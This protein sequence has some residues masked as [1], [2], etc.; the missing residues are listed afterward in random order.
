MSVCR[1]GGDGAEPAYP[2]PEYSLQIL[3]A[4]SAGKVKT[5]TVALPRPLTVECLR[6]SHVYGEIQAFGRQA[7]CSLSY[8]R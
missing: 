6:S 5:E 7:D 8:K 2:E 3:S 4:F 1:H